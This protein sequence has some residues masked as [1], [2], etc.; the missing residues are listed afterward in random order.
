MAPIVSI[1]DELMSA[2][3]KSQA[4]AV[5]ERLRDIL[6]ER[7]AG[8][9]GRDAPSAAVI[10]IGPEEIAHGT[11]VGHF[12]EAIESPDVVEGVDGGTET[13]VEAED[14]AVDQRRQ[15]QV[16]EQIREVLPHVG[17][18]VL[19]Q[20]LVVKTVHL[21]DLAT[22][23]VASQDGYSVFVADFEGDEE[24]DGLHRIVA[25]IHVI[26][27]EQV[28]RIRTLTAYLEQL[29]EVVKLAMDIAADGDGTSDF[30]HVGLLG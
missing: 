16:I 14:L 26:A 9:S 15:R 1:H 6:T 12:L 17:V 4:I 19:P 7:V 5:V 28:I 2:G 30:L 18:A 11:L 27:H 23:V 3:H 20:T 8:T 21:G 10:G 22:L 13:P 29:H 25:S 24:S